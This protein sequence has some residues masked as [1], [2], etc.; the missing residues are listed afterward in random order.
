MPFY[1][2]SH[3]F[4]RTSVRKLLPILDLIRGKYADDAS[5]SSSTCPTGAPG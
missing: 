4:A 3:R 1:Q 5:T 2:A